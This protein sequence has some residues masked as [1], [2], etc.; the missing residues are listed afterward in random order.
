MGE[1]R[2]AVVGARV[3]TG[4]VARLAWEWTVR[5]LM[6]PDDVK[7]QRPPQVGPLSVCWVE[8]DL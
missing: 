5:H 2:Q 7:T 6:L 3:E 8:T 1:E 4:M